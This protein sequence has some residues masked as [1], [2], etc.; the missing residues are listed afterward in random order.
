MKFQTF[1]LLTLFCLIYVNSISQT[2]KISYKESSEQ[3]KYAAGKLTDA[4]RE[5]NYKISDEADFYIKLDVNKRKMEDEAFTIIS[6]NNSIEITG[7]DERGLIY[8]CLALAEDIKNGIKLMDCQPKNEKPFLPFRTIKFDL[9][10]DTYRHSY[11]LDIHD[12]TCRDTVFWKVFL[13]MMAENRFNSLTLW[14]LHPY[15]FLIK[16]TNFPESSPWSDKEMKEWQ[17]LFHSIMRMAN[18]RAIDTYI[19][20]FNIFVTP[21]FAKA[22][23]VALDNLEHDY[24]VEGDTSEI[25]KQYTRECVTQMLE[26]Y[27]NLTGMGLTLGEGMG[28]MTPAQREKWIRETIIEGMDQAKRKSKLIH[29]IPFSSTTASLGNTSI[30]TE[31]MTRK[32]IEDEA[33]LG[34]FEKPIWADLKFNWSHAHSTPDLIKVHGGKL[35]DTYFD[36]IPE[37]YKIVWTARNEDFFCL[38]WGVPSFI[39]NHIN[40]NKQEYSGGYIIGSETYIPAKDYFTKDTIGINWKY[41][42]ERQ[43]LFYKLWGRLLY[44]PDTPDEVFNSEFTRRYGEPGKNLLK[45]YSYASSTQLKI[46]SDFD[47]TWDFTLYGEGIMAL[48]N[49]TRRV[50][51]ISI[52]RLINQLPLDTNI[53][54][55]NEYV[56]TLLSGGSF[57]ENKITPD[58]LATM[59]VKDCSFAISLTKEI[60]ISKN[61]TLKYEVADITAWSFLGLHFSEK[62]RGGICLQKFRLTG[63]ESERTKAVA[64]LQKALL[65]WDQLIKLTEPLYNEMPLQHLSQQEGKSWKENYDLRFHWKLL[66]PDVA[67]DVETARNAEFVSETTN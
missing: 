17:T 52:D 12:Q 37:D 18:E 39:R 45:A 44:N 35:Y 11:A 41:A 13:D 6:D 20:P 49:Q 36:P 8:G 58:R 63:D 57:P 3:Q 10:W 56:N 50:D 29:R 59:F 7:G 2:V 61:K 54:S 23:N 40:Q 9:P 62:I 16:P 34:C 66:R 24:Y 15:T 46:A 38:R 14:N 31:R 48:D 30:E 42:F 27:P 21:E 22:H 19:I 4:L 53:V 64:H 55:I 60:D 25:I 65:Y 51:Y 28:G 32:I 33:R 26:E 1:L 5:E 67:K 47:C 43:W